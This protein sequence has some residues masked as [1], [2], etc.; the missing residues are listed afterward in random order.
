MEG[1]IYLRNFEHL[2]QLFNYKE[3][4][5]IIGGG[6]IGS[7]MDEFLNKCSHKEICFES[8]DVY[9]SDVYFS[10]NLTAIADAHYLPYKDKSFDAV[11]IQ[12]VLEHV[13]NPQLVVKEIIEY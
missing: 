9:F 5:L 10:D 6:T 8:I 4:V 2:Y 1:I 3:K 12:A 13:I 7:G 11:I